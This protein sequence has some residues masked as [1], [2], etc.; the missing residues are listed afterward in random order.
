MISDVDDLI[1]KHVKPTLNYYSKKDQDE[2]LGL[3]MEQTEEIG[4][5]ELVTTS[6]DDLNGMFQQRKKTKSLND[7]PL[8]KRYGGA[9]ANNSGDL[10]TK[11][12]KEREA[13]SKKRN[14]LFRQWS[15]K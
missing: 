1:P 11:T 14:P 8:I 9:A 10:S 4:D 5:E 6:V 12:K 3:V 15:K 7:E 13:A 2:L